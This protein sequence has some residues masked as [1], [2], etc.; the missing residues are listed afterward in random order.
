MQP[1]HTP[2]N[3]EAGPKLVLEA[4]ILEHG[5][6]WASLPAPTKTALS[7]SSST[8]IKLWEG[9]M[10]WHLPLAPLRL[11]TT[12]GVNYLDPQEPPASDFTVRWSLDWIDHEGRKGGIALSKEAWDKYLADPVPSYSATLAPYNMVITTNNNPI[13]MAPVSGNTDNLSLCNLARQGNCLSVNRQSVVIERKGRKL[14]LK[15]RTGSGRISLPKPVAKPKYSTTPLPQFKL[16][17]S[18]LP[19][20]TPQSIHDSAARAFAA[21]ISLSSQSSYKTVLKHLEEAEAILGTKFSSPPTDQQLV[22]FTAFLTQRNVA[23]ATIKSYLSAV[24]YISLSRGAGRHTKLPDLGAQMVAGVSNMRKNAMTEAIKPKRRPITIHMLVLLRH[25]IAGNQAWSEL[26]KCLRWSCMLTSFWGSFRMSELIESEKSK[27]SPSTSLLPSDIK[28]HDESVAIWIRSPKVWRHGGDV[29]EVW[30][31]KENEDLDPVLAL[32]QYLR[33]RSLALGPAED[34]PVF[35]HEDGSQLTKAEMNKDIK[36]LLGQYPSISSPRDMWSGHSFRAGISTLL[37]SLGF[38]EEQIKN[39]GRWSSSA[40][41]AYVQDQSKR[42]D[43]RKQL[44]GVFG[45]MLAGI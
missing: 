27:F 29:V 12:P 24:R 20:G 35:L 16:A 1:T 17:P 40:Y 22:F 18:A 32:K 43:T 36:Q 9:D 26:E 8:A 23:S 42:R 5:L 34:C 14:T 7:K 41:L 30:E 6:T 44:T 13:S 33:L 45:Q 2:T 28:F 19:P 38:T 10:A 21:S 39:W 3:P 15:P 31:V 37:T 11:Y 25:A 4:A